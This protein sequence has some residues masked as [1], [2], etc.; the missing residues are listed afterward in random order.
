MTYILGSRCSDGVVLVADRRFTEEN[1]AG[2][3]LGDKIYGDI[4]NIV[5][6][7]SGSRPTFELFKTK[8]RD[9][10]NE[11]YENNLD[12]VPKDKIV[13][14]V[15]KLMNEVHSQYRGEE[16]KFD[17]LVALG[18]KESPARLYY[19]YPDGRP[20]P[21]ETCRAIG[22]EHLGDISYTIFGEIL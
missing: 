4:R 3:I 18:G 2:Y 10:V 22:A 14:L 20:L 11:K 6:G 12:G 5:I 1:D 15:S 9:I 19:F 8:L 17:S 7:F 21:V 16:L 13:L